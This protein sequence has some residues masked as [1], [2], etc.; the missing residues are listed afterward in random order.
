MF[1]KSDDNLGKTFKVELV[2]WNP[3]EPETKY[4]ISTTKYTFEKPELPKADVEKITA[5]TVKINGED[6]KLEAEYQFTPVQP[7]EAQLNYYGNWYADYRVSMDANTAAESF[8]LFGKYSGYGTNYAEGFLFPQALT[9][10]EPVMLLELANL[11]GVTYNDMVKNIGEFICGVFNK[12]D[13][14]LGKTFTVELVI[15]NPADPEM[16]YVISTTT[17]T[18]R[19]MYTLTLTS[20]DTDGNMN[21]AMLTGGGQFE[22][23]TEV[24]VTAPNDVAGFTFD[25]WYK[26]SYDPENKVAGTYAYTFTI[27][28]DT[29]LVAVYKNNLSMGLL[30]VKGSTYKVNDGELQTSNNDFDIPIGD[31]VTLVYT[32]EDFL[33]WVNISD[34]IV[35]TSPTYNF[36]MVDETT[37]RLITSRNMEQNASA[38][39]VF[40]NAY[41]QVQSEG[42]VTD[43]QGAEELFPKNNPS[44]IGVTFEKW[45]FEGTDEEATPDSIAARI[46]V[47]APVVKIV[48]KYKAPEETYTLT[49]KYRNNGTEGDVE[50]YTELAIVSGK[51][52]T[53]TLST[54]IDKVSGLDAESFSYW[55]LDG[56]TPVSFDKTEYM[57]VATKGK[58]ITLTAVF[59]EEKE[60]EPIVRIEQMTATMNGEKYRVSTM[61]RYEVPEGY[62]VHESGFV[63]STSGEFTDETLVIG[64]ENTKKHIS[65]FTVQSA[66]YVL[67]INFT[68]PGKVV[69][70][71]AYIIY[72]KDGQLFTQYSAMESG[73]YNQLTD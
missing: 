42:R 19:K 20:Q 18:F 46:A 28:A 9:A 6:V 38:Y 61:M 27:E 65:N 29:A 37:L 54:I 32:G 23:G 57:V 66:V 12:S 31:K 5:E 71:K 73:S 40:L 8:G 34:N 60:P 16:K 72:E 58:T 2:I 55:T 11:S 35:S 52:K 14:N 10:N 4:V 70:Y 22:S 48:P 53:I 7:T 33:Y 59:G 68:D 13:D 21:I 15:W 41:S 45:V 47:P 69:Y 43:A 17:Y 51:T 25:G 1:N 63:R 26:D 67:N 64:A 36:T 56:T 3:A 50:G 39:A 24:T 44:K 62:I 49:V 30:H